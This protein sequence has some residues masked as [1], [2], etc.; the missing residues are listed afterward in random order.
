MKFYVL[1][2]INKINGFSQ[3][4]DNMTLIKNNHWISIDDIE[5]EKK[6]FIFRS[7]NQLLISTNG[8]VK[9]STWEYL[10]NNSILIETMEGSFLFKTGFFDETLLALK[11]D[12]SEKFA[13]FINETKYGSEINNLE[14]VKNY[15][16]SKYLKVTKIENDYEYHFNQDKGKASYVTFYD[17]CPACNFE[18]VKNLN[19]CPECG[20]IYN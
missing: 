12:S 10:G 3:K 4:I 17:I 7:S 20:L 9:K 16:E 2:I 1:D 13:L 6:V 18:G 15:I 5:F 14:D 11:V 19:E 8:I